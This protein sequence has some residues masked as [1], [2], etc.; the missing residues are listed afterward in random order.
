M[1][2]L[3]PHLVRLQSLTQSFAQSF[4]AGRSGATTIEYCLLAVMIA[5]CLIGA[6]TIWGTKA[7]AMYDSLNAKGWGN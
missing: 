7:A 1:K 2:F 6:A 4:A 3:L 5:M